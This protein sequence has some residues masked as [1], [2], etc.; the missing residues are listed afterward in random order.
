MNFLLG[1]RHDRSFIHLAASA[2]A[3]VVL[4][5]GLCSTQAAP[6]V[7]DDEARPHV[8]WQDAEGVVGRTA[9]VSG[10]VARVGHSKRVHFLN[11]DPKRRDVFVVVIFQPFLER[12][13]GTLE[14]LYEGRPIRVRGMVTRFRGT[15]QIQVSSPEQIE[16]LDKLPELKPLAVPAKLSVG[17]QIK[18]ATFNVRN[19]FDDANDAY[20]NDEGTQAKPRHE[21]EKLAAAIARLDADVLAL[22]EVESRGYLARFLEVFAP[23]AG[24][25]DVVHFEGNDLRGIDVC[26][27][28]RLPVGPVTSFRH[29]TFAD[30]TGKRQKFRRDLLCVRL[31][32]EDGLPFEVWVAHLKS[33][34][35]GR[36]YAE[37]VRMAEAREIRR[38]L[39]KRL[40]ADPN[41]AII[42]CGDFNDT[43]DSATVQTITGRGTTAL[44]TAWSSI[45]E[46]QRITYNLEP[47]RSMI[48]FILWTPGMHSR[49]VKGTYAILGGSLE[50]I[51]SDHNPVRAEF[52]VR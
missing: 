21:L 5:S 18:V 32:P 6:P 11:F 37:P 26:L 3:G 41:A 16:V 29:A 22:Q 50:E 30:E 23:Q 1:P 17:Q 25:Q 27:L 28:S 43:A 12:F 39:D 31:E 52:R 44:R 42:V 19:L 20:H 34:S 13:E 48:D 45:P 49:Y 14:E 24:Y 47:Y 33:N 35:D 4:L 46:P 10:V 2:F 40:A 15:P 38:L 8:A 7:D 9:F 36:E 51:G